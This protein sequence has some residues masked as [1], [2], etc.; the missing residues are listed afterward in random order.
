MSYNDITWY[1]RVYEGEPCSIATVLN[2][3]NWFKPKHHW[4]VNNY[5]CS[6]CGTRWKTPPYPTDVITEKEANEIFKKLIN[7][8]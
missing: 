6:K 5:H 8:N 4:V 7:D 1:G 3:I 2:P